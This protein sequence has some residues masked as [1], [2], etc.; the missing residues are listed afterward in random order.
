[1]D[2]AR[3]WL[4]HLGCVVSH[5]RD[6]RLLLWTEV[7]R[8]ARQLA[9][10]LKA[11]GAILWCDSQWSKPD[12]DGRSLLRVVVGRRSKRGLQTL[13][14]EN[15]NG[16]QRVARNF[17]LQLVGDQ[18]RDVIGTSGALFVVHADRIEA[19]SAETG[20]L[21]GSR[22]N[23]EL[24]L[25]RGRF[26]HHFEPVST[27]SEGGRQWRAL[28]WLAGHSG[29]N[30]I[31]DE[32]VCC[33]PGHQPAKLLAV[34]DTV[35]FEGPSA[36][37][38]DGDLIDVATGEDRCQLRRRLPRGVRLPLSLIGVSRDGRRFLVRG[39]CDQPGRTTRVVQ[40]L[41]DLAGGGS[42]TEVAT[43]DLAALERPL[44]ELARPR[45][46]HSKFRAI[47]VNSAGKLT[48]VSKRRQHWPIQLLG[49]H[50]KGDLRFPA[51]PSGSGGEQPLRFHQEFAQLAAFGEGYSLERAQWPDGSAA[52]L[53]GRGLLHLRSS[54]RA[55]PEVALV[56]CDGPM[57]GWLSDGRSF[58][59]A[60][61]LEDGPELVPA[62][63]VNQKVL[64]PFVHCLT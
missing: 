44:F 20:E 16:E 32:L 12:T 39:F 21:L 10:G 22:S 40:L 58:G 51:Q 49:S 3:S 28:S 56:L 17:V 59:P 36:L 4:V 62:G 27:M 19:L 41:L 23:V 64:Q 47:G 18:P 30:C 55:I 42:V 9:S 61:W 5:T 25:R 13:V 50:T 15:M 11:D 8:G 52:W 43:G 34:T 24:P 45:V 57:A 38:V 14:C 7:D 31:Q 63:E 29:Q 54:D 33:E 35:G 37:T 48:L 60:W 6:G 46:T 2:L 1:V 26:F 53:D